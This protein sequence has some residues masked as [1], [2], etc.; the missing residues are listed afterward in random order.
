[1]EGK[2]KI[3]IP[4]FFHSLFL[5]NFAISFFLFFF[6]Q[7]V[8]EAEVRRKQLGGPRPEGGKLV[9]VQQGETVQVCGLRRDYI[10]NI[11]K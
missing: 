9:D 8:W 5:T 2:K 6:L 1:M 4:Y 11:S 10:D 7:I 3:L